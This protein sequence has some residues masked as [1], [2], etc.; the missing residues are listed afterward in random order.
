MA[1]PSPVYLFKHVKH[2]TQNIQSDCH[3]WLSDSFRLHKIRF[4]PALRPDPAGGAYSAPPDSTL[5]FLRGPTSKGKGEGWE[6]RE[7][8]G[9]EG[10]IREGTGPLFANSWICP[11]KQKYVHKVLSS[12]QTKCNRIAF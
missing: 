3:Q 6:K 8:K 7:D 2:G 5:S 11:C 9:R 4:R 10:E 1:T 12:N